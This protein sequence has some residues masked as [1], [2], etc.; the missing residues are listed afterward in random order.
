MEVP[1]SDLLSKISFVEE[2][3]GSHHGQ[4]DMTLS[5]M[6]DGERLGHVDYSVFDGNPA[7]QMV[8]TVDHFRGN[9]I[10][11][12]L[13]CELQRRYPDRE[14]GLGVLTPAGSGL[15]R[16]VPFD[17][18]VDPEVAAGQERLREVQA[19]LADYSSRSEEFGSRE[20]TEAE[21]LAF[22]ATVADWNDLH[23][24]ESAL[25]AELQDASA[26]K[27]ILRF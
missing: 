26:E 12:S 7:V 10:G 20:R 23:D 2:C 6:S 15:I 19:R 18:V 13:L 3:R 16:S 1:V 21:R 25:E 22:L 17:M 11:T 24:E 8:N 4:I 9:G 27:R 5:A 14:I